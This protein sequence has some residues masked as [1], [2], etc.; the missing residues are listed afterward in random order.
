[1]PCRT[2]QKIFRYTTF[3]GALFTTC[4]VFPVPAT[5]EIS[6]YGGDSETRE[7]LQA[8]IEDKLGQGSAATINLAITI[9]AS[10]LAEFC[11]ENNQTPVLA[12]HLYE[13]RYLEAKANCTQPVDA[14]FSDTPLRYQVRLANA[15]FAGS[16]TAMLTSDSLPL[17]ERADEAVDVLLPVPN[18]GVAKGLGRLISEGRWSVFLLPIDSTVY[19]GVDYRLTLE[20][21]FRHRRAAIV[22]IN[23][24][25]LK[26]A[27]GATYYTQTQ[28]EVAV[29][30]TVD[31]FQKTGVL[32]GKRPD[33]VNV[34]INR[35]VLRNLYGRTITAEELRALETEVNGG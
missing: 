21:L 3:L 7:R 22:S 14:I 19:K 1:M 30:D 33:S 25:L 35:T 6:I 5:A 34:G 24:L 29:I 23:P 32:V 8:L 9:G 17:T 11:S 20:T 16:R 12:I 4:L 2:L 13:E 26:G 27:V 15:L 28:L 10:A 31:H 18:E